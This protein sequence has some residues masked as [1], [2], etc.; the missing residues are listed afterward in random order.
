MIGGGVG[1]PPMVFLAEALAAD[2]G[3]WKPLVAD[4]IRAV[5][6]L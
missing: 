6:S 4:G 1:I 3:P 5:V 2:R